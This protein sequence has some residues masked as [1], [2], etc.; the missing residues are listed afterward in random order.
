MKSLKTFIPLWKFIKTE[1]AKFIIAAI[2]M[3]ISSI[4]FA[5]V[6]Y[7]NGS[8]VEAIT[9]NNLRM[10]IFYLLVYFFMAM[11]LDVALSRIASSM[12]Q[13]IE[14]RV[15]RE[16][17]YETY[18]KCLD[19]PAYAYEKKASG[20]IIN[21]VTNDAD[22]LSFTFGR[23][24]SIFTYLISTLIIYVYIFYNSWE[25][26]LLILVFV[27]FLGITMRHYNPLTKKAHKE[28]KKEHDKFISL[29]NESIRGINIRY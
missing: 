23:V 15:S 9:N 3:F 28:R 7:L 4:S 14:N 2:M 16:L 26:A 17:S 18:Q 6:G 29:T 27:I 10:A 19:L 21:R 12:L 5:F 24:L 25:V 1:K 20:E 13:K 8:A 11:V 22:T